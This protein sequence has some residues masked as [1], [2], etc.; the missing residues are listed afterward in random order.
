M[1]LLR[2]NEQTFFCQTFFYLILLLFRLAKVLVAKSS[3]K[4]PS[5]TKRFGIFKRQ[6]PIT[7]AVGARSA[8]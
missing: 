2:F 1:Q 4:Y 3:D 6:T 8:L 7:S 5:S